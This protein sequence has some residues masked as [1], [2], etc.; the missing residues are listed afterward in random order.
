MICGTTI[1]CVNAMQPVPQWTGVARAL[2]ED[3]PASDLDKPAI[4]IDF[5]ELDK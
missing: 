4:Q 5:S 3:D 2:G 1:Y